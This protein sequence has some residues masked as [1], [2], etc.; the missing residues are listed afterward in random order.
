M[1]WDEFVVEV[2]KLASV[3]KENLPFRL[4][5]WCLAKKE[6]QT[7]PLQSAAGFET[8]MKQ[9][10]TQKDINATIVLVNLPTLKRPQRVPDYDHEQ[11]DEESDDD[12]IRRNHR[13]NNDGS[14]WGK[15]VCRILIYLTDC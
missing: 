1:A 5:T 15:K 10:R 3:Q 8:M 14:L 11:L 13:I 9:I 6:N 4:I 12:D 2:A 7:Y